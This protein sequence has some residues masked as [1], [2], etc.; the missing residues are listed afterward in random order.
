MA[1]E[2]KSTVRICSH[3]NIHRKGE[4]CQELGNMPLIVA[5]VLTLRYGE[6][7]ELAYAQIKETLKLAL[8]RV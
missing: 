8:W 1:G 5:E 3:L 4:L 2:C 7:H 6:L